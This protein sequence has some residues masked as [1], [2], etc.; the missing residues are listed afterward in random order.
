MKYHSQSEKKSAE[1][2]FRRFED[3]LKEVCA[4]ALA[5]QCPRNKNKPVKSCDAFANVSPIHFFKMGLAGEEFSAFEHSTGFPI[6]DKDGNVITKSK[7][8][9]LEKM[10]L[11]YREK[12]S[13]KQDGKNT[14][15]SPTQTSR[16]DVGLTST[17]LN[18]VKHVSRDEAGHDN[19]SNVE[20][21]VD[22][23]HSTD[24]T[25]D[26]LTV[27]NLI[28]FENLTLENDEF[29]FPEIVRGTFGGRQGLE[30]FSSGPFTH[31]FNF[32]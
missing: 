15:V 16:D 25:A 18:A 4:D 6:A 10:L 27:E 3:S 13:K 32:E 5:K 26:S 9:K 2:L 23:I 21:G 14:I 12:W 20:Y 8:K 24:T 7:R 11:K 19:G 28:K 22:H 29:V 1:I 31:C 17:E 30:F